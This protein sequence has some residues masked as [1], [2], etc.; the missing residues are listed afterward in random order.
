[1]IRN[2]S[3]KYLEIAQG[4]GSTGSITGTVVD[5]HGAAIAGA[6]V[7]LTNA[8]TDN[9]LTTATNSH[10]AFVAPTLRPGIYTVTVNAMGFKQAGVTQIQIDVGKSSSIDVDMK[11]GRVKETVTVG[12]GKSLQ[13]QTATSDGI[14][15]VAGTLFVRA[16]NKSAPVR[17]R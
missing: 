16:E 7:T 4:Q 2:G 11:V 5:T 17:S 1:M 13:T 14:S 6:N 9:S 10:G 8:A 15:T 12:A 3:Q